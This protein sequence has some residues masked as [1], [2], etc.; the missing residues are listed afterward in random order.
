MSGN[1]LTSNNHALGEAMVANIRSFVR[2]H[3]KLKNFLSNLELLMKMIFRKEIE[4]ENDMLLP[5]N[6]WWVI[7]TDEGYFR[8]ENYYAIIHVKFGHIPFPLIW[9][10]IRKFGKFTYVGERYDCE[11]DDD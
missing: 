9:Y 5:D 11:D 1:L 8:W 7:T 3:L 4:Y 10:P 6:Q 2:R